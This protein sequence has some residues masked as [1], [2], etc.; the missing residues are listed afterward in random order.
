MAIRRRSENGMLLLLA[1]SSWLSTMG[2]ATACELC[3]QGTTFICPELHHCHA[4]ATGDGD[5]TAT[6]FGTPRNGWSQQ[7]LGDPVYLTYSYQ[8]LLDGGLKDPHGN[9]VAVSQIRTAIEEAFEVWGEVAPLHFVEVLDDGL[10]YGTS[11]Q[12][13]TIRFRH[14]YINGPDPPTGDP[15][16]KARAYFPG[17][18]NNSG[19]VEFDRGD[20]WAL[21]GT[22]REPD[23]LG[24]AI[25]EIGHALGLTHSS[26][27][28]VNMYWIFKR[29]TGP[30]SGTLLPDDIAAIQSVYG[31]GMGSV[32][33]LSQA[34]PEPSAIALVGLLAG[35]TWCIR[36]MQIES[37]N[38]RQRPTRGIEIA[39]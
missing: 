7:S 36:R 12:H 11:Q 21:V 13:G 14:A 26:L 33:P 15:T 39:S 30:G 25:H 1:V 24:A 29:H 10:G 35:V 32:T 27:P 31:A 2:S 19:D 4:A 23:I 8:N 34:V 18:S 37:D 20:P 9:S 16:T 3:Q 22:T 28:G 6:A 17:S 38:P 5:P